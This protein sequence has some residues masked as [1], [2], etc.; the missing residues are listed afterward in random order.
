MNFIETFPD[1]YFPRPQQRD[2]LDGIGAGWKKTKFVICNAPTGVGKTAIAKAIANS[3]KDI[4]DS[5]KELIRCYDAY[6]IDYTK[7]GYAYHDEFMQAPKAS[8]IALTITKSLQDQ[9]TREFKDIARYKGKSNY[10]CDIDEELSVDIGPCVYVAGQRDECW[11][12]NRCP[13]FEARNE[14]L[15]AKFTALNYN[16]Y[17]TLPEHLKQREF[18]ICDEASEIEDILVNQYSF[19]INYKVI[20]FALGMAFSKIPRSNKQ[21]QIK[22]LIE[23]TANLDNTIDA[24]K[25]R[26]SKSDQKEQ[27]LM[28]RLTAARKVMESVDKVIGAWKDNEYLL[29]NNGTNDVLTPLRVNRFADDLFKD[30]KYVLLMSATIVDHEQFA[31][32]LG[33]DDYE[34]V[35]VPSPF[36]A[37]KSPIYAGKLTLNHKTLEST[38]PTVVNHIKVLAASHPNDKGVIHTHTN[39]ITKY[40]QDHLGDTDRFIFREPGVTNEDILE[41]HEESTGPSVLVSPSLTHGVDLKGELARW[42]IIIKLP[43]LPLGSVRIKA[44]FDKDKKW[45]TN[46]MMSNLIQASGRG[47]RSTDDWCVTYI[48]DANFA[49]VMQQSKA[50]VP[51]YFLDR[52]Q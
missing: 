46:K 44:L 49:R 7:G 32:T 41:A 14:A 36:D 17:L 28:Q 20:K 40:L 47:T 2:A 29:D 33:I 5:H 26:L 30:A 38:L 12:Q 43:Y 48:F 16:L 31:R 19:E 34:Y 4:S 15:T 35:E 51:S 52:V 22:W 25:K 6:N 21:A 10:L 3:S 11:M 45:Y 24:I 39:K 50:D 8:T 23:L 13:Y 37:N 9:Y 18:L 1:G 42:Q 27:N